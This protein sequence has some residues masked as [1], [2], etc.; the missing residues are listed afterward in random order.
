[1]QKVYNSSM[2]KLSH[3]ILGITA[4]NIRRLRKQLD[5]SQEELA[6]IAGCHRTYV[7]MVERAEINITITNL[8]KIATALQ[9]NIIELLK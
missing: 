5:L 9:V 7:G 1:M 3:P 8:H 4:A 2:E 6:D